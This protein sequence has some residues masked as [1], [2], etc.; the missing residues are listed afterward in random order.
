MV[1]LS[2]IAALGLTALSPGDPAPTFVATDIDGNRQDLAQL[3]A[4]GAVVLVFYPRAGTSQCTKE[5][6]AYGAAEGRFVAA[7]ARVLA[8][9]ADGPEVLRQFRRE[10]EAGPLPFIADPEARL[11]RLYEVKTL[12][13]FMRMAKRVTFVLD[14][15]CHIAQRFDDGQALDIDAAL[16]AA[17]AAG[18]P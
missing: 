6:R 4:Q 15:H 2:L 13:P 3:C 5:L 16:T 17:T 1:Y 18:Q 12:L 14:R 8:I 7:Q 10:V 9:S 11:I